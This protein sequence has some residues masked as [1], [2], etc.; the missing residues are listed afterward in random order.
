[1]GGGRPTPAGGAASDPTYSS[2]GRPNS[3]G[4]AVSS[5]ISSPF[6]TPGNMS[7]SGGVSTP[8]ITPG[9]KTTSGGISTPYITPGNSG[10]AYDNSN[11][12]Y[13]DFTGSGGGSA[14]PS[15]LTAPTHPTG[16][17]PL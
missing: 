12:N 17:G 10:A 13:G 15:G 8:Y 14:V 16:H 9:N 3:A 2:G 7:T 6:V 4:G 11:F 5:G 1:M